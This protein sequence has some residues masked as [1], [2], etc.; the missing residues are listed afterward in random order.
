MGKNTRMFTYQCFYCNGGE[1]RCGNKN[2]YSDCEGGRY[3]FEKN[4][5]LVLNKNDLKLKNN[6]NSKSNIKLYGTYDG[7]GRMMLNIREDNIDDYKN[8]PDPY[9]QD[10]KSL[11]WNHFELIPYTRKHYSTDN[12]YLKKKLC[13]NVAFENGGILLNDGV[14][15]YC[16]SCYE[17]KNNKN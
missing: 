6:K 13:I 12:Y 4:M 16:E 3:C 14:Y 10:N 7:Y 9:N 17:K 2:C 1:Y 5:V 8:K 11:T 15:I